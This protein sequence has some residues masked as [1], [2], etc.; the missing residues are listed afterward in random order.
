VRPPEEALPAVDAE[1]TDHGLER[2]AL[3]G[4]AQ[5]RVPL[6]VTS[7]VDAEQGVQDAAVGEVDLG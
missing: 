3:P 1:T 2:E 7:F 6:E 5:L 4:G